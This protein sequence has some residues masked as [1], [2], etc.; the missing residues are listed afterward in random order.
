[1]SVSAI[2]FTFA[3]RTWNFWNVEWCEVCRTYT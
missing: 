2:C 1:M 3:L